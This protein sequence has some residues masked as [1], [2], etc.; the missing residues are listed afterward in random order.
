MID[1]VAYLC[2]VRSDAHF[3]IKLFSK[4]YIANA[5]SGVGMH[6]PFQKLDVLDVLTHVLFSIHDFLLLARLFSKS[7]MRAILNSDAQ[8]VE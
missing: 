5:V 6:V 4:Y 8:I 1:F 2:V 3:I 7:H